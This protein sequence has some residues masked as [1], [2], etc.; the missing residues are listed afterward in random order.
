M[1]EFVYFDVGGVALI[2]FSKTNKWDELRDNLSLDDEG[3]A[4]LETFF[5]TASDRAC[6]GLVD[7]D[8][9]LKEL[10]PH[11]TRS[12]PDGFS[13]LKDFVDRFEKNETMQSVVDTVSKKYRYGLLTNMYSRMLDEIHRQK[14]LPEAQ[15]EV[16]V[17]SSVVHLIKP[18]SQIFELATERAGVDPRHI[19]FIDNTQRHLDAAQ[20]LG[21]QTLLYDPSD[22]ATSSQLILSAVA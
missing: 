14:L 22:P 5:D 13:L 11:I 20:K 12:L 9:F 21:W 19:L 2:D 6:R 8:E 1:I 4:M 10:A 7:V 16:V 3:I 17:D 15:W 18:E